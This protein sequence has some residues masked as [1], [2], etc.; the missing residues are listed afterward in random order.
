MRESIHRLSTT[1]AEKR[2]E[3][4][5]A[6]LRQSCR[7]LRW[8]P[9]EMRTPD[10]TTKR[11]CKLRDAFCRWAEKPTVTLTDSKP[12]EDGVDNEGWRKECQ[13]NKK[14]DQCHSHEPFDTA[15]PE[16]F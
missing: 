4:D 1:L 10:V 16:G 15:T 11:R 7:G 12:A 2:V 9:T 3:I 5:M 14:K 8:V 13:V 6:S